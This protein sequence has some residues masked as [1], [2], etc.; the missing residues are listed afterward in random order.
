MI[1]KCIH[2]AIAAIGIINGY[3]WPSAST[4]ANKIAVFACIAANRYFIPRDAFSIS[5]YVCADEQNTK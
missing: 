5:C 1:K 4:K 2:T 3:T